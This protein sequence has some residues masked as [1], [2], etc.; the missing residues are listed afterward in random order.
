MEIDL[1]YNVLPFFRVY[2]NSPVEHKITNVGLP[3]SDINLW[4]ENF[5]DTGKH[6]NYYEVTHQVSI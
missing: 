5:P 2:H 6:N 4:K 3:N 1:H